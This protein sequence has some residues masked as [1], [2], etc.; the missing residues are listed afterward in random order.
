M[1]WRSFNGLQQF[2]R[3]CPTATNAFTQAFAHEAR[4]WEANP[5]DD[6]PLEDENEAEDLEE[7]AGDVGEEDYRYVIDSD[8]E[9]SDEEEEE[10]EDLGGEDGEEP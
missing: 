5:V 8:D 10:N 6:V 3:R 2:P 9:S 1:W 7:E 4:I